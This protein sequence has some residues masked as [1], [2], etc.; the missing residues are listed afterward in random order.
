MKEDDNYAEFAHDVF[1]TACEGG[2]N[3]WADVSDYNRHIRYTDHELKHDWSAKLKVDDK[4]NPFDMRI[5]ELKRNNNSFSVYTLNQQ[6]I[7]IAIHRLIK[8]FKES[9]PVS[10]SH[11]VLQSE[12]ER[13][14]FALFKAERTNDYEAISNILDA[15]WADII[16]QYGLFSELVYD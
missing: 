13:L 2:I 5:V 9:Q 16:V 11:P 7:E 8:H 15:E 4:D 14:G 12:V 6:T 3:Y 10:Y 1:V